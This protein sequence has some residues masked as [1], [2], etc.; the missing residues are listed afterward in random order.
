MTVATVHSGADCPRHLPRPLCIT[1]RRGEN[2]EDYPDL[3]FTCRRFA[4]MCDPRQRATV[5]CQ[6]EVPS[7]PWPDAV[8]VPGRDK[9]SAEECAELL[10]GVAPGAGWRR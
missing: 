3:Y 6:D 2:G 7:S 5:F 4:V 10:A 8:M 1:D 9:F